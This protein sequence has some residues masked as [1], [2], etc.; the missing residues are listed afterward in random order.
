[1]YFMLF[2]N[3]GS[4]GDQI[5]F[6]REDGWQHAAVTKSAHKV[7][8]Y[9]NGVLFSE[10]PV[11]ANIISTSVKVYIGAVDKST[12]SPDSFFDGKIDDIYIHNRELGDNEVMKIFQLK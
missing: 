1:M 12:T 2:D 6:P 10:V 4:S 7:K 5:T 8:L 11:T 9:V 3:G